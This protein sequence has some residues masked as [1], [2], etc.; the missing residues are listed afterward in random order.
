VLVADSKSCL[1]L[2]INS[3][4]VGGCSL[5]FMNVRKAPSALP[6]LRPPYQSTM[7]SVL[8]SVIRYVD[9][10]CSTDSSHRFSWSGLRS[11]PSPVNLAGASILDG[12]IRAGGGG[13]AIVTVSGSGGSGGG[14]PGL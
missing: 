12:R 10:Y 8:A 3:S 5:S 14:S 13:S 11:S 7:S 4:R 2:L 1:Y 9:R 6:S